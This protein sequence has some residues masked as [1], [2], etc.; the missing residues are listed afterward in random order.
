[1]RKSKMQ[2]GPIPPA[3]MWRNA[4]WVYTTA[5]LLPPAL[6]LPPPTS[7]TVREDTQETARC[8]ATRRESL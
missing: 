1:M 5:T 8:T 4:D 6:T 2:S 7:A 3:L